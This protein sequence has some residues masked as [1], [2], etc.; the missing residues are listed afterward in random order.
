MEI[1]WEHVLIA[2]AAGVPGT[3]AGIAAVITSIRS[4]QKIDNIPKVVE[5]IMENGVADKVADKVAAKVAAKVAGTI[6][7]CS[8]LHPECPIHKGAK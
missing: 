7:E 8:T 6:E 5:R 3:L 4:H 2:L 1:N